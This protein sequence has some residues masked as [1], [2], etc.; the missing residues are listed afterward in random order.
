M[1][2]TETDIAQLVAGL[3]ESKRMVVFSPLLSFFPELY[4]SSCHP[5]KI[6]KLMPGLSRNGPPQMIISTSLSQL[7][8]SSF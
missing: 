6:N 2:G 4:D 3:L 7:S 5:L 1:A 8:L